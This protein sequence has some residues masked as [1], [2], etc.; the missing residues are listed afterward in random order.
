MKKIVEILLLVFVLL[1]ITACGQ[2]KQTQTNSIKVGTISGPET[3]LMEVAKKVAQQQY[4]LDIEIISFSDYTL[5]NAALTDGSIDANMFQHLPFLN[6]QIKARHYD[7]AVVGK[8]F[9]YPMGAYSHKIKQLNELANGATVAI[10]NDASNESRA[11]LLLQK[12]QLISLPP[13]AMT[14]ATSRDILN[15]PKQLKFV[16]LDAAQLPR[17]LQDVDL[18][19][20]NTNYAIPAGLSPQH[21]ALLLEDKDSPYV[22]LVVVRSK[23]KHDPRFQQLVNAL[24]S[25][26]VIA[27]AKELFGEG[28]IIGWQS[29]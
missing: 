8:A 1:A 13:G 12:A 26:E 14:N 21:D 28:A 3:T 22:N 10:P 23:D 29:P 7:L 4:G 5:P 9:I 19:V 24:H 20:I 2:Q 25:P 18:A 17:S 16:E 15:N 6:E 27:K 11:L